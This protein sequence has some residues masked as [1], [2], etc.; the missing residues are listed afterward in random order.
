MLVIKDFG[1]VKFCDVYCED[2][3]MNWKYIGDI[4]KSVFEVVIGGKVNCVLFK[5]L[6][7]YIEWERCGKVFKW[8]LFGGV[9]CG[10][11]CWC[12]VCFEFEVNSNVM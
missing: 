9:V 12:E 4:F 11:F 1:V 10:V 6:N 3:W 2:F 8:F 7:L 5:L